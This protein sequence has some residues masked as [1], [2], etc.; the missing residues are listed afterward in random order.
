MATW[1]RLPAH[2]KNAENAL[3]RIATAHIRA[4]DVDA[5]GLNE[6]WCRV[7]TK[8][9]LNTETQARIMDP[10]YQWVRLTETCVFWGFQGVKD[11]FDALA[12]IQ[13][14]SRARSRAQ[15]SMHG[16]EMEF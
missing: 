13:A 2:E 9:G 7:M 15:R 11:R 6:D 4:V 1:D 14:E 5:G 8:M 10:E 12:F 3:W 16:E